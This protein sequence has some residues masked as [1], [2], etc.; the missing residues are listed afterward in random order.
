MNN[1]S[2]N[3]RFML[4]F[5][6]EEQL[7]EIAMRTGLSEEKEFFSSNLERAYKLIMEELF[8]DGRKK[9]GSE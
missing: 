1:F 9:I 3:N 6:Y 5:Y 4:P 8:G 2:G 7:E